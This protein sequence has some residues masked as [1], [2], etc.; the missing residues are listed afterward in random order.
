MVSH[1]WK[2]ALIASDLH[3]PYHDSAALQVLIRR[4]HTWHPDILILNGDVLDCHSVSHFPRT[5]GGPNL[6]VEIDAARKV[7]KRL[8]SALGRGKFV[9]LEGNHEFRLQRLLRENPGLHGLKCLELPSLLEIPT[10]CFHPQH[11]PYRWPGVLAVQ[12]ED[13]SAAN[14]RLKALDRLSRWQEPVVIVGHSH[15]LSVQYA[16]DRGG[17]GCSVE[18]GCLCSIPAAQKEYVRRPPTWDLGH[19]EVCEVP[20]HFPRVTPVFY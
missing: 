7:I 19:V 10:E 2:K 3:V 14:G 17:I 15:R 12:H 18:C 20:G 4:I 16:R 9:Y 13:G 8:R 5:P 11:E 1:A 6:Q